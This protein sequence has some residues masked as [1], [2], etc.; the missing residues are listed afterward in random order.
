MSGSHGGRHQHGDGLHVPG[1][2]VVHRV[3]AHAALLGVL[4]FVLVV[5]ATPAGEPLAFA[6]YAVLL[7]LAVG[8]AGL[9]PALV[10]RRMVVEV[11]FVVFALLVPFVASGPQVEVLG[12]ALSRE[13]LVDAGGLLAK[14]TLGVVAAIL[15]AATQHPR[16][17]LLGLQ[18]LRVPGLL[19]AIAGSMVRYTEVVLDEARRMRLARESRGFEGRSLRSAGVVA[20]SVGAL[21]LRSYERGERVHLAML[22]RGWD[23]AMPRLDGLRPAPDHPAGWWPAAALPATALVLLAATLGLA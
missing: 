3:P 14:T 18:R 13:G 6:G 11:P 4:G 10:L 15:L 23:G 7:V 12:L 16:D 8:L 20:R 19:V 22:S 2:S 1:H 5:V 9:S 17:L 21:F